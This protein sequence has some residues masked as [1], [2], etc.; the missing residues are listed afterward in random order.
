MRNFFKPLC[1]V[2]TLWSELLLNCVPHSIKLILIFS[3]I[4]LYGLDWQGISRTLI[5]CTSDRFS[6]SFARAYF[7]SLSL[8]FGHERIYDFF[9]FIILN[10]ECWDFKNLFF[11]LC[12]RKI[13]LRYANRELFE[14]WCML[15][16]FH[17]RKSSKQKG[18]YS[19]ACRLE[20]SWYYPRILSRFPD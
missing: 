19:Q 3:F 8:P 11:Y 6:V 18:F 12:V 13:C 4:A 7:L 15:F 2:S 16:G 5:T 9:Y 20:I 10:K 14:K 17:I 1:F